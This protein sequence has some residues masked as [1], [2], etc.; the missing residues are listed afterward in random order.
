MELFLQANAVADG[1][2]VAVFLTLI[3]PKTYGLLRNLVAPEKPSEKTLEILQRK[4]HVC[5]LR[6]KAFGN[7]RTFQVSGKTPASN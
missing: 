2:K 5:V 1:R 4:L 3:G 6:A 7:S